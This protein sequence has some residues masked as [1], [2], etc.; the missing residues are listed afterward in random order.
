MHLPN[1]D[2]NSR[3]LIVSGVLVVVAAFSAMA[4]G[5]GPTSAA[6]TSSDLGGSVALEVTG[7]DSGHPVDV[8][9][10]SLDGLGPSGIDAQLQD[11]DTEPAPH[12]APKSED[13]GPGASFTP[14]KQNG[15]CASGLC[16]EPKVGA[17]YCTTPCID[18]CP[19]GYVCKGVTSLGSDVSSACVPDVSTPCKACTTAADCGGSQDACVEIGASGTFCVSACETALDCQGQ[20]GGGCVSGHCLPA[21]GSCVCTSELVGK[22]RPCTTKNA[23]GTCFGLETCT[24]PNGWEGCTAPQAT[25][26][27]CNGKDDDCNGL[28]DDGLALGKCTLDNAH[29]SCPGFQKCDGL[30]GLTCTG[31]APAADVCNG[32]DDDCD[33]TTDQGAPDPDKDGLANCVDPDD[34]G[35]GAPDGL[36]CAPDDAAT[37]PGKVELCDGVD[38][39]CDSQTDEAFPNTDGDAQADCVDSDDDGDGVADGADCQPQDKDVYSGAKELCNGK[40]D[41]CNDITDESFGDLDADGAADCVDPDVDGDGDPNGT[42]CAPENKAIAHGQK[43]LCDGLDNDCQGGVDTG[44]PDLDKDGAADCVDLDDDG[45]LVIDTKDNCP[46]M[47][48]ADQA[49]SDL[50][51]LGDACDPVQPGPLHHIVIRSAAGGLGQEVGASQLSVAETLTLHAAGYDQKG[52]YLSE[53]SCTWTVTGSLDAVSAGPATQVTF[54][55]KT[56]G[57]AGTLVAVPVGPNVTQDA[58]GIVSVTYPPLGSTSLTKSVIYADKTELVAD[59]KST[60]TVTVALVDDFGQAIIDAQTVVVLTTSGTLK[61]S[62][63][64]LGSGLYIQTLQ[65]PPVPGLATLTATVNGQ[66]LAASA[67]VA[68]IEEIDLIAAGQ[69]TVDC[70]NYAFYKNKNLVVKGGKV[71]IN[72]D[73]CGPMAFNKLEVLNGGVVTHDGC[74]ASPNRLEL[75]LG[76]LLVDATSAIDVDGKG[77]E[78]GAAPPG[79]TAAEAAT[80]G[81]HGGLA[82]GAGT[83]NPTYD[84]IPDPRH[85]GAAGGSGPL[86]IGGCGGGVVRLQL[87]PGGVATIH[88]HISADGL[89]GVQGPSGQQ[90]TYGSG[91]GGSVL[92]HATKVI[93]NGLLSANGGLAT[94]TGCKGWT[95]CYK[96]SRHGGGGGRIA[97]VGYTTLANHFAL[98]GALTYVTA[99]GGSGPEG[100]PCAAGT[101]WFK[102]KTEAYGSL[103]VINNA[104]SLVETVL[105]TVPEGTV[106]DV[107]ATKLTEYGKFPPDRY[108]G[109]WIRPDVAAGA[110]TLTDN[111]VLQVL[112]NDADNLF[113]SPL[114]ALATLTAVGSTYRG[115]W[116]L[117]RLELGGSALVSTVGDIMVLDGDLHSAP[118]P[119][120]IAVDVPAGAK[121]TVNVFEVPGAKPTTM[122]GVIVA[123]KKVCGGCP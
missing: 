7:V 79:T 65:A 27:T 49:D 113:F 6:A 47:K 3:R 24:G 37:G 30:L 58:T 109:T 118:I 84:S 44:F 106:L 15:D 107:S 26:E 52:L 51:G 19:K 60:T 55:P 18:V 23:L 71:V 22:T 93:G 104:K 95:T 53:V 32:L 5:T 102:G 9:T 20:G 100:G 99:Y 108:A 54:A 35:D 42:D 98:P 33:G 73:G 68:F 12:D 38:N 111:P 50:D 88:G 122:T 66:A 1:A 2:S 94:I 39:D 96:P 77:Y 116:K 101:V 110:G 4:C 90:V 45:D 112:G 17:S 56:P 80:G 75:L 16:Y 119:E 121:L 74:S 92:V 62:V 25:S 83:T 115:V 28:Q 64:Y 43:E 91:A 31:K 103:A 41:N 123:K 81:S 87:A 11:G 78:P 117:S 34:D 72:T 8:A 85:A 61:G 29:G 36:D 120:A 59:G 70:G 21:S 69:T 105:P 97:I 114:D 46:D 40:D 48:N 67:T 86:A 13:P 76:G 57:T 14:C 89:P 10:V 63:S 82:T